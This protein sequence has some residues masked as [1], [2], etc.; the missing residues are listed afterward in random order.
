MDNEITL[1]ISRFNLILWILVWILVPILVFFLLKSEIFQTDDIFTSLYY[2]LLLAIVVIFA[3]VVVYYL[4]KRFFEQKTGII[5]NSKGIFENVGTYGVGWIEW[6]DII[7][8]DVVKHSNVNHL[9]IF[10]NKPEKYINRGNNSTVRKA[11]ESNYYGF[12]SP[13]AITTSIMSVSVHYL[14]EMI[15]KSDYYK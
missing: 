15:E 13:I 10:V 12:G 5:I 9:I 8:V 11:L 7:K 6:E 14:K 3:V 1:P 4:L 2:G